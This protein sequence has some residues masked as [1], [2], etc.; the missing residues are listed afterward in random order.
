[1]MDVIEPK[2]GHGQVVATPGAMG[3]LA[4]N[5]VS[6]IDL[7]RRHITG[8][9]GCVDSRDGKANDL[10]IG[11]GGRIMSAYQITE[12]QKVWVITEAVGPSGKRE[13]TCFLLPEEY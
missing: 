8:D 11:D 12:S 7:L 10:A 4:E 1:M 5:R 3:L 13:S 2:F 6:T 9:W